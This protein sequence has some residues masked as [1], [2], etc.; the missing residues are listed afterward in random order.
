M[1]IDYS[2]FDKAVDIEGLKHDIADAAENGGSGNYKEVPHGTYEVSVTKMEL[3]ESKKGDPMVSIWFKILA[4]EYKNS[5]IFFNQVVTQG[6]QFHIV[7]ELLRSMDTDIEIKFDSY[8]QYAQMLL[9]VHEAIDNTLEFVM[10]YG[11]TKKGFPTFEITEV[12]EV[13]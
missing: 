12:Y 10:D 1:A 3:T 11:E 13:E 4:G 8:S 2:K 6:F 9:D 5:L 7:N